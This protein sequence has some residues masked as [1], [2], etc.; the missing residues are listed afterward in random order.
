MFTSEY[1]V[2]L[3]KTGNLTSADVIAYDT[4]VSAC[5]DVH[6]LLNR[7][8][9]GTDSN[10]EGPDDYYGVANG[11]MELGNTSIPRK[12]LWA[13]VR[14]LGCLNNA[15]PGTWSFDSF[16]ARQPQLV[17]AIV[18]AAFPSKW[19]PLHLLVRLLAF[20]VYLISAAVLATSCTNDPTSD[21][22][23]RRLAWHLGNNVSKVSILN[24]LAY[25]LWLKR[26]YKT[27]PKGMSDVA[28]IYYQP[29]EN[30]PY[31]KWWVT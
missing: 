4:R 25:K 3:K 1:F 19:N 18:S 17:C 27:Y 7:A 28:G 29:T 9:V 6:G 24:W 12:F 15:S 5:V 8:P 31:Q 13:L 23:S 30:N 26:L 21:A 20:P 22:D 10:L 2:M 11:C 14:Y 16:F